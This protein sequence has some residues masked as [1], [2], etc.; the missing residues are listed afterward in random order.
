MQEFEQREKGLSDL[1]EDISLER[2]DNISNRNYIINRKGRSPDIEAR[3]NSN[4]KNKASNEVFK[5]PLQ[6]TLVR[7]TFDA[8]PINTIDFSSTIIGIGDP[9]V[10]VVFNYTVPAGFVG[11]LRGFKYRSSIN[12]FGLDFNPAFNVSRIT[13]GAPGYVSALGTGVTAGTNDPQYTNMRYGDYMSDYMPCYIICPPSQ[14][15]TL[16]LESNNVLYIGATWQAHFYG[17]LLLSDGVP[18]KMQPGIHRGKGV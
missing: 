10:S 5:S 14:T 18:S 12:I 11:I 6:E 3:I 16:F 1:P 17:N 4:N 8:R 2:N 9:A 7:T 15:I 13:V